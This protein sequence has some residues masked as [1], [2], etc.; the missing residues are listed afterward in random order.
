MAQSIR[1][2]LDGADRGQPLNPE[3]FGFT[4]NEDA[5]LNTRIIS[6]NNEL[7]FG[8]STYDY[9]RTL[10]IDTGG[11]RLV[12]VNVEY[13]CQ[14]SWKPLV[15]G[16]LIISE[17]IFLLDKCQ[18]K[19]RL[20]DESFSTKINNNKDIPFSLTCE[21][22]KNLEPVTP[23]SVFDL[24]LFNPA[25]GVYDTEDCGSIKIYDAFR[26]L[27]TCMSDGLIDFDSDL[28]TMGFNFPFWYETP[29]LFITN[30]RAMYGRNQNETIVTFKQLYLALNRKL[31]L[32]FQF[33]KQANGRPLLRIEQADYFYQLTPSANLYDQPNIEMSFD[34]SQ[35]FATVGFGSD[36]FL[37]QWECNGGSTACTF[38][39]TPFRGFK[40]EVFGLL[41]ECN[42]NTQ[43]DLE[44][45]DI[46]FDTNVIED[47][48]RFNSDAYMD[49]PAIIQGLAFGD[50]TP[51][52]SFILAEQFDPY[53]AG[54]TVYN[55]DFTNEQVAQ[56]WLGGFPNSLYQYLAGF[57]P[58]LTGTSAQSNYLTPPTFEITFPEYTS[59]VE[60][61][62]DF[63]EFN[64]ILADINNNFDGKTYVVPYA[65]IYTLSAQICLGDFALADSRKAFATIKHYTADDTFIQNINGAVVTKLN[66]DEM[67]VSVTAIIV[68]N[69]GDL[70]RADVSAA[71]LTAGTPQNQNVINSS[72]DFGTGETKY[73]LFFATGVPFQPSELEP[74]DFSTI[75]RLLYRFVRPITMEQMVS[76]LANTSNQITFGRYDDPLRVIP[77][78]I[79]NVQCESVIKQSANFELKSNQI[80]Q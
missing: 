64:N 45:S 36:P 80:L 73:T 68:C 50:G 69:K 53:S 6:F 71:F 15:N 46:I 75:K 28:F 61:T 35:L 2:I 51:V 14:S 72:F 42:T 56:N 77:G 3:D 66:I 19:T 17:C 12:T 23:P 8:G 48:Q 18:V 34:T 67:V 33:E 24:V 65:G 44:S 54:Q 32:G 59:F 22:T 31:R 55:G 16:W 13:Q 40:K 1:F 78:Y 52:G 76:I 27:I 79:K 49:N 11:C 74:V 41:G 57:N 47:I 25:N 5:E 39:Q 21:V 26:H 38:A 60:Y 37:E 20:Y 7:I 43:L 63:L 62:G 9:L 4:I 10:L 30:G 58:A 29:G 70:I